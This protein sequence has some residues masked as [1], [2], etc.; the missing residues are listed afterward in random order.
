MVTEYGD[1]NLFLKFI[2]TFA[3][4]RFN[5]ID[6]KDPLVLKLEDMMEINNQF[7]YIADAINMKILYTSK[8]SKELIGIEPND[9][10]FYHFMEA[11]HP[12]DIQRLNIGRTRL[13][14]QAQNIFIAREGHAFLSTNF[15]V[16]NASGG[17]SDLLMQ[18]YL[19]YSPGLSPTVYLLKIHTNIDWHKKIKCGYHYCVVNDLS[20]FR[21]PD[22]EMLNTGNVFTKREFEIIRLIESGHSTEQIAEEL[23]LSPYTVNTHRGNIL[24]KTGK[25][26]LS[27]LIYELKERGVL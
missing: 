14:R 24:K 12:D 26:H 8:R 1:Y 3:P 17:Y 22:D 7:I 2:E 25:A 10:S 15:K 5:G 18:N 9:V 20:F 11:T 16:R 23:F 6:S 19:F 27:E 21:Y 13:M 4:L